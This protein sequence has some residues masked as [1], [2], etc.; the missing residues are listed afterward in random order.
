MGDIMKPASGQSVGLG[1]SRLVFFLQ[2]GG[3]ITALP[4]GAAERKLP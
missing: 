4:D 3:L 2:V 1:G